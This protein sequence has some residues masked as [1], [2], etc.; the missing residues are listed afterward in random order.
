M[1]RLRGRKENYEG[2]DRAIFFYKHA[3]DVS[4][5]CVTM[6]CEEGANPKEDRKNSNADPSHLPSA[7][8]AR[9]GQ[10]LARAS[11]AADGSE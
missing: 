3:A 1:V 9:A 7:R 4:A 11:A 5:A 10:A 6:C 8:F 2:P